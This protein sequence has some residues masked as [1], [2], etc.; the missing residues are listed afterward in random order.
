MKKKYAIPG[1]EIRSKKFVLLI[2]HGVDAAHG[3]EDGSLMYFGRRMSKKTGGFSFTTFLIGNL[4]TFS[5]KVSCRFSSRW[6]FRPIV[7]ASEDVKSRIL[8]E[9]TLWVFTDTMIPDSTHYA[10]CNPKNLTLFWGGKKQR[11][12][13]L[14]T[15]S[16]W[17]ATA[18][19]R[20][21]NLAKNGDKV[22]LTRLRWSLTKLPF[23]F[24]PSGTSLN[25]EFTSLASCLWRRCCFSDCD[26]LDL[27][28]SKTIFAE[29]LP[30][31][32]QI[33]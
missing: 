10:L 27:E 33:I 24:W 6:G 20:Y 21:G 3:V 16:L 9:K 1:E 32:N 19:G 12:F 28:R 29:I 22:S 7:T 17:H 26:V 25:V 13:Q 4:L 18:K 2:A 8:L 15:L 30:W 11:V 14:A 31:L 23:G 5:L